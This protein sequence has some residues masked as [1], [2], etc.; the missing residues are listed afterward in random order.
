MLNLLTRYRALPGERDIEVL[1]HGRLQVLLPHVLSRFYDWIRETPDLLAILVGASGGRSIDQMVAHL[2]KAQMHH[3]LDRLENGDSDA[4]RERILRIG[5]AHMRIGLPLDYFLQGY[6]FIL[7]ECTLGLVGEMNGKPLLP[8]M[9]AAFE[10][11]VM[12]DLRHIALA[13]H[14]AVARRSDERIAAITDTLNGQISASVSEIATSM[15][16]LSSAAADIAQRLDESRNRLRETSA[17]SGAA[18]DTLHGLV[19]TTA[20]INSIVAFVG[21]IAETTNLLALNASIEAARAGDA[22][23]GFGVV[24]NEVKKLAATTSKAAVD[25]RRRM[26]G[27]VEN[28]NSLREAIDGLAR[29]VAHVEE[30]ARDLGETTK[31]Q[32]T[33]TDGV[34]RQVATLTGSIDGFLQNLARSDA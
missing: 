2:T 13:Y 19:R 9:L 29:S 26:Q 11:L 4:Y 34:G 32:V 17:Q 33:I 16:S 10:N 27:I 12:V 7:H 25:I 24:A 28:S 1:L 21:E 18:Q 6:R 15:G 31:E 5:A 8:P 22:G 30:L 23:L 14:E 3:W 20:D